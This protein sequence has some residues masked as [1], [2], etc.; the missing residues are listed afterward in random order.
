[1][2]DKP[3]PST[4]SLHERQE[5]ASLAMH[6]G[7]AVLQRLMERRVSFATVAILKVSPTDPDRAQ[8][9][10]NLQAIAY[11]QNEFCQ[12]I[13]NDVN[14]QIA[15]LSV[16][17]EGEPEVSPALIKAGYYRHDTRQ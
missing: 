16:N 10:S 4:L 2:T 5:L 15:A 11:A 14:W 9:I 12:D 17:D 1:M 7:W 13:F 8:K 6:G 3:K